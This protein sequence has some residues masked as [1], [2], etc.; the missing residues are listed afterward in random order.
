MNLHLIGGCGSSGTTLLARL[1]DGLRTIRSGPELGVFHHRALYD[2]GPEFRARVY[3]LL[4][5]RAPSVG[6]PVERLM[7]PLMPSVFFQDRA[8]YGGDGPAAELA[9]LDAATDLGALVETLRGGM[10]R[11]LGVAPDFTLIDQTPKNCV[12]AREF[13]DAVP[14]GRFIHVVRDGR[15]VVRSLVRRWA[16]EAKGHPAATYVQAGMTRWTW[17]VSQALR[18]E[19]H[20][21]YLEVRYESLVTRPL[22]EINR[23]LKHLDQAPVT[24]AE[25][26]TQHSPSLS[27]AGER[28]HGGIKPTWGAQVH[29]P[30]TPRGVGRWREVFS[31]G[32]VDQM[33][34]FA[35][36]APRDPTKWRMGP[37]L[38]RFAWNP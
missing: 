31:D 22:V 18:A 7:V 9:L 13:L 10:A 4:T 30:V 2:A 15:D 11:T 35:F 29:D 5:G 1:L 14:D 19:D 34:R 33:H 17:D 3:G 32:L 28:F 20:P 16:A 26:A 12:A 27:A 21:G 25:L 6:M 23:I 24:E 8:F 38:E 37:L 36:T